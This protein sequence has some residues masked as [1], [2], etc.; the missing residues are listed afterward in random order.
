MEEL[1]FAYGS[2]E[3]SIANGQPQIG[4]IDAQF[5]VQFPDIE[6]FLSR[7]EVE[8]ITASDDPEIQ[9]R[10]MDRAYG[11]RRAF[12]LMMRS[13]EIKEA[14]AHLQEDLDRPDLDRR[15]PE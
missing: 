9:A 11:M 8:A 6:A 14:L 15:E 13:I 3:A 10:K 12:W 7:L 4:E 5:A 2:L 1:N